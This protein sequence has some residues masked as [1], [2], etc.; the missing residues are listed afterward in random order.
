MN[1]SEQFM[2]FGGWTFAIG[3][4]EEGADEVQLHLRYQVNQDVW[5]RGMTDGLLAAYG[6]DPI[7]PSNDVPF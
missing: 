1:K 6:Y 4:V 7:D 5:V 3:K 2:Y